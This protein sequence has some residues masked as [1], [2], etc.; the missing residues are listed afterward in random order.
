MGL[1]YDDIVQYSKTSPL[2]IDQNIHDFP[3]IFMIFHRFLC[4]QYYS[5]P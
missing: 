3:S 5:Y 2:E 1:L 4:N